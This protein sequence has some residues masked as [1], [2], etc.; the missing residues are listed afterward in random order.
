MNNED[1]SSMPI[2]SQNDILELIENSLLDPIIEIR[3]DID[4]KSLLLSGLISLARSAT[5]DRGQLHSF[6]SALKYPVH[7]TQGINLYSWRSSGNRQE[8]CWSHNCASLAFDSKTMDSYFSSYWH[9]PNSSFIIQKSR[10]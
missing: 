9:A 4:A 5:M 2:V 1:L 7:C 10:N 3:R 6:I 8:L